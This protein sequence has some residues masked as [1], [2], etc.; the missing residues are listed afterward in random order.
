[1]SDHFKALILGLVEGLTEFIPVSSTGHL[2]LVGDLLQFTGEKEKAFE[3]FIQLGA[4]LAVVFL[5]KAR[6]VEL[7][8]SVFPLSKWF[9]IETYKRNGSHRLLILLGL[10]S[11]V[12]AVIG[13]LL[14]SKIKSLFE[15]TYVAYAL[16]AGG[17]VFFLVER[18][19]T[20]PIFLNLESITPATALLI[21][22]FQTLALWPGVSRSGATIIG[23]IL[24]GVERS[25]AA[26]FS[27]LA[28]VPLIAAAALVDFAK[29]YSL[30]TVSD[31]K[32]F[33]IG[34]IVS[35]FGGIISIKILIG[36]LKRYSLIPF[37][38]YRVIL[39]IF[40]LLSGE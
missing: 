17:V 26:D 31:L 25:V 7:F 39:G 36:A 22:C 15:P 35:F 28:A 5:Y 2:I 38:Y 12:P 1:M 10:V 20:K 21:G 14:H 32:I 30:L 6:F 29:V 3:V 11:I 37:A 8:I 23:A 13:A 9:T 18:K 16:I 24:L 27:F 33:A 4:I 19:K 40:I 34:L